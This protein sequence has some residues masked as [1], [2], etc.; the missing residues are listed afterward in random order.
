MKHVRSAARASPSPSRDTR[1]DDRT[2]QPAT[3][4]LTSPQWY[5][6]EPLLDATKV[7][8]PGLS[9]ATDPPADC[10][11]RDAQL[12]GRSLLGQAL[13]A[14]HL[15][16]PFGECGWSRGRRALGSRRR[17][18]HGHVG[19]GRLAG[20]PGV[21]VQDVDLN[22]L[23]EDSKR[24]LD[25]AG[26]AGR[27]E[28]SPKDDLAYLAVVL[29]GQ[30]RVREAL[31]DEL[32]DFGNRGWAGRKRLRKHDD[33][34]NLDRLSWRLLGTGH[35]TTSPVPS[36]VPA[37]TPGPHVGGDNDGQLRPERNDACVLLIQAWSV[38]RFAQ[39]P[40]RDPRHDRKAYRARYAPCYGAHFS[41]YRRGGFRW[42][43]PTFRPQS[44]PRKS[45]FMFCG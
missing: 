7:A 40:T 17:S 3:A 14:Q 42:R 9:L 18:H 23:G 11:D 35:R 8:H 27:V 45:W 12:P 36:S 29:V 37:V 30:R 13:P 19:Q 22:L 33:G 6:A 32:P 4:R 20:Q 2:R 44:S 39:R 34:E 26:R 25:R 1:R 5:F 43:R 31:L 15:G 41:M 16:H 10:L 24:H 38:Y 21:R 28:Q